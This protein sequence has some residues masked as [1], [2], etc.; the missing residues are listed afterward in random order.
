[1][2]GTKKRDLP[3]SR[4]RK[5]SGSGSGCT[6]GFCDGVEIE[7]ETIDPRTGVTVDRSFTVASRRTSCPNCGG[8]NNLYRASYTAH[9]ADL[10]RR[11]R[12][13]REQ[14]RFVS[15]TLDRATAD[16]ADVDG[17]D[18]SYR[19]LTGDGGAWTRGVRRMRSADPDVAYIGTLT[20]RPSDRRAHV[21]AV[22][23]TSLSADTLT[24]CLHVAGLDVD[25][26]APRP[27][28]SAEKFAAGCGAY[29]YDNHATASSGRFVASRGVGY[30]SA[31]AK[32]RR[33]LHAIAG[34]GATG[35]GQAGDPPGVGIEQDNDNIT[36]DDRE[37]PREQRPK[38]TLESGANPISYPKDGRAPPV[39]CGGEG[40]ESV[41]AYRQ[42]VRRALSR[43]IGSFV[44]VNGVGA[45][46]LLRAYEAPAETGYMQCEVA[47]GGTDVQ[48]VAWRRIEAVSVPLLHRR[49]TRKDAPRVA[50][51]VSTND[52]N[53][54][55]NN[56]Q[57][58]PLER[59]NA[60]A[61]TSKVTT[62]LPD[63]RRK[64]SVKDHETGE[65]KVSILPPDEKWDACL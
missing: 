50:H 36:L 5:D 4:P 27:T 40:V 38:R 62:R 23:I 11:A 1:M 52:D 44:S 54:M 47:I 35:D 24:D 65:V 22:V 53:A 9:V 17:W 2:Q 7:R 13:R 49:S 37:K 6:C 26:R 15:C 19:V 12:A 56:S 42:A 43:R 48:W 16:L 46:L 31:Q 39:E 32:R 51:N 21:H 63:G 45:A 59:F 25:V 10:V 41:Q 57:P 34:A 60:V 29:A 28:E 30:D 61:R 14:L 64:V 58:S 3:T 8:V 20:A 55:S 18:D 33:Q